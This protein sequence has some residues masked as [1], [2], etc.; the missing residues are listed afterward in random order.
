M[1]DFTFFVKTNLYHMICV[2]AEAP[3]CSI[4]KHEP[5]NIYM[6]QGLTL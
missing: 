5:C 3:H 4:I 6:T 1:F 2:S